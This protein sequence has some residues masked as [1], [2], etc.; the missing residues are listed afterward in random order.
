MKILIVDDNPD[1]VQALKLG[2][3]LQWPESQVVSAGDGERALAVFSEETPDIV[4][5]DIAMP[6]MNGFEVLRRLRQVSDVPV[7]MLTVKG[8]EQDKVRALELGADDYVTKPFGSLELMARIKAV[9]RRVAVP[10]PEATALPFAGGDL[11]IDYATRIVTVRGKPVKLTPTEYRLLCALARYPNQVLSHPT[12]LVRV[13]GSEYRGESD[14]LKVYI[15]RLRDKIEE[16]S[17]SPRHILTE[18]G[19][20]Y[21]LAVP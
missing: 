16:D 8:D 12:L 19:Q 7:V 1:L 20:G 17:S 5:L 2:F 14:F 13:W 10:L 3:K 18:W 21:R 9:L 11:T 4:L 15:K 6:G